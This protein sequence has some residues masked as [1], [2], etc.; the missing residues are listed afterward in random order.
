ML[1]DVWDGLL[2]FVFGRLQLQDFVH[3][4]IMAGAG[5]GMVLGL[6]AAIGALFYFKKW[7]WLWKIFEK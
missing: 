5:I 7:K 3:E 6:L 2:R 4:P 1:N